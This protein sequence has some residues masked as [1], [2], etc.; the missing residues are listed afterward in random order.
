ME[1]HLHCIADSVSTQA[2][3]HAYINIQSQSEKIPETEPN[4]IPFNS[5]AKSFKIQN[6]SVREL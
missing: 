4:R 3:L 2:H 6:N 1:A 5:I